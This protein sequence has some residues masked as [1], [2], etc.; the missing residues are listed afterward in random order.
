MSTPEITT[1]LAIFTESLSKA[2]TESQAYD[3]LSALTAATVGVKLF[4]I[5]TVDMEALLARRAYTNRPNAYPTSGTKPIVFDD[6]FQS[7]HKRHETFVANTL[8]DISKVFGD[9]ELIGE[10]GCGSVVNLPILNK[11]ELIATINIL[12]EEQ[13]YT[14]QKVA[15]AQEVLTLP[16]LAA[17]ALARQL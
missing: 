17:L 10:L 14:P 16:A 4:T 2:T 7:V 13:F 9:Y 1:A 8:E 5:M 12:H 3:A 11:G 15:L 6:W